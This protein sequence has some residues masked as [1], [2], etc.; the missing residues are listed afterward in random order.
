MVNPVSGPAALPQGASSSSLNDPNPSDVRQFQ[1]LV[2]GV[3]P[4]A[5]D[6]RIQYPDGVNADDFAAQFESKLVNGVIVKIINQQNKLILNGISRDEN[7][8]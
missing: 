2:S 4:L 1:Q 5:S 3:A 6:S 7:L 8:E